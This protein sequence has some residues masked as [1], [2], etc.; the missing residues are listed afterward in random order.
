M[1]SLRKEVQIVELITG[2]GVATRVPTGPGDGSSGVV[3]V[4]SWW[5]GN[6]VGNREFRSRG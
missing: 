2:L 4:R 1:R 6:T 5:L 3:W